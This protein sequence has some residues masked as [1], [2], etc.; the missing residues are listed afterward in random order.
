MAVN[1]SNTVQTNPIVDPHTQQLLDTVG[2]VQ[3]P[4]GTFAGGLIYGGDPVY[5]GERV[6]GFTNDQI[7][8]QELVRDN[9]GAFNPYASQ[10]SQGIG[11]GV[12]ALSP[13]VIAQLQ[14]NVT[15]S[16]DVFNADRNANTAGTIDAGT[17][18]YSDPAKAAL[19]GQIGQGTGYEF[20][21]RY[22]NPFQEQVIDTTMSDLQ[23][24]NAIDFNNVGAKA[25][26]AGAFGGGRH[27]MVEA[28]TLGNYADT[29]AT[30]LAGL[31]NQGY[32][33]A[34]AAYDKH[35][36]RVLEGAKL[37]GTN[38]A[39]E[40]N[41]YLT[42]GGLKTDAQIADANARLTGAELSGNMAAMG[43][44]AAF[45]GAQANAQLGG[46]V[47]DAGLTD[48]ASL[49]A[50]GETQQGLEQ[51]TNDTN[52]ADFLE[53]RDRPFELASY[54]GD[55]VNQVP[56]QNQSLLQSEN[57]DEG[58][59]DLAQLLGGIGTLAGIGDDMGWWD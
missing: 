32:N 3:Q 39:N 11:A 37:T 58:G 35:M 25:A 51:F 41:A 27:G 6:A 57:I 17:G 50:V 20:D 44:D 9:V 52:Y 46:L 43:S 36:A 14:G 18:V 4:D 56:S 34:T 30:T 54:Y 13:E 29:A 8:A 22:F 40:S 26:S 5:E 28:E 21:E 12:N 53:A 24:A 2:G 16:V 23:R 38:M 10:A 55:I 7:Q 45:R 48:A 33:E 49:S 47:H 19:A 15:G 31:R 59:N 1:T 42:A